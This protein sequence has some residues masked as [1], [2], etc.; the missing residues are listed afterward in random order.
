MSEA[1][2]ESPRTLKA[3]AVSLSIFALVLVGG[4]VAGRV[5][6]RLS[7]GS[8]AEIDT[9]APG[10]T[11]APPADG[12]SQATI[13]MRSSDVPGC[14]APGEL[15]SAHV[16]SH[17]RDKVANIDIDFRWMPA[18]GEAAGNR[19]ILV[20]ASGQSKSVRLDPG[21][22]MLP[23]EVHLP[24]EPAPLA[25]KLTTFRF[26]RWGPGEEACFVWI[27]PPDVPRREPAVPITP[28]T[29]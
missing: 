11:S 29:A 28:E 27:N 24:V 1:E 26:D 22:E 4:I 3:L 23:L 5:V 9:L 6:D 17:W 14:F 19:Q 18:E 2:P 15:F 25:I 13:T 7:E 12:A 20:S 8:P 21:D 16:E 10:G